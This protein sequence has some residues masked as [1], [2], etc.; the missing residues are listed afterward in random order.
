MD[1]LT[2]GLISVVLILL[3]VASRYSDP[4][5]SLPGPPRLPVFGNVQFNFP[6]LHLQFTEFARRYGEVYRIQILSQPAIVINSYDAFREA[7][8][9][10]GK[11]FVGRPHMLR[12]QVMK[13]DR[14]I[15][16]RVS[17]ALS[18]S[19]C[20]LS[21]VRFILAFQCAGIGH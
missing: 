1:L 4:L 13:A 9:K 7:Y 19:V 10:R 20:I 16:F 18:I 5:G 2:L 6:R 14:G 12:F 17:Y 11:D 8:L 15:A 3:Y 21:I